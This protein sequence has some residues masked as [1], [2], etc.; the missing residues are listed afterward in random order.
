MRVAPYTLLP[1]LCTRY[2][3]LVA[4]ENFLDPPV[5]TSPGIQP[6]TI[7]SPEHGGD[8]CL[9]ILHPSVRRLIPIHAPRSQT[10][11]N[12][13]CQLMVVNP[14]R[15]DVVTVAIPVPAKRCFLSVTGNGSDYSTA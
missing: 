15:G 7:L 10:N 11:Y 6:L 9:R 4:T 5:H 14:M 3:C 8:R 13:H 12:L 2:S 1:T